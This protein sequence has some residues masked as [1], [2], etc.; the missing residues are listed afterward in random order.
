M[1]KQV[2]ALE[3]KVKDDYRLPSVTAFG[4]REYVRG[5]WRPVPPEQADSAGAHP[6]LDVREAGGD[7]V[8]EAKPE[9]VV[10]PVVA[11]PASPAP[12]GPPE[13]DEA[14]TPPAPAPAPRRGK[15]L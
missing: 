15:S 1:A 3:A 7:V 4:G 8:V 10:E 13:A 5:A 2:K 14:D 9:A 6:F 12:S 11:P